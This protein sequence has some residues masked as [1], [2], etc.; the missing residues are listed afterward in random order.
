VDEEMG[1]IH[2]CPLNPI[3]TTCQIATGPPLDV[4]RKVVHTSKNSLPKKKTSTVN[5]NDIQ[6]RKRRWWIILSELRL[7]LFEAYGDTKPKLM[8]DLIDATVTTFRNTFYNYKIVFTFPDSR[9]WSFECQSDLDVNKFEFAFLETQ[10]CLREGSSIYMKH[11]DVISG[12]N[13]PFGGAA[14]NV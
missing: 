1:S 9:S 6:T 8:A 3:S 5:L 10:R 7:Y 12:R 11:Q 2:F 14:I 4:I 13:R